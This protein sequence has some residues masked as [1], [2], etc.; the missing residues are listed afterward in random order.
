MRLLN[1]NID[2]GRTH[3]RALRTILHDLE[4]IAAAI[5]TELMN[6]GE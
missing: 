2:L 3:S 4:Q 1:D 6:R 5:R